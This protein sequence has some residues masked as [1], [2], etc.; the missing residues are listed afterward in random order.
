MWGDPAG[1]EG[2]TPASAWAGLDRPQLFPHAWGT[3]L[4]TDDTHVHPVLHIPPKCFTCVSTR[5]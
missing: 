1:S 3:H 4:R 5:T 2:R